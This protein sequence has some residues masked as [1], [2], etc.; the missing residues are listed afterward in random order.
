MRATLNGETPE[1]SLPFDDQLVS[2]NPLIGQKITLS[3]LGQINCT[4]CGRKTKKSFSQGYCYPCFTRLPQCDRCIVSPELCHYE[5][6]TCR[7]SA[8]GEQHCL[9]SH[10]VYLANTSGLKVGI[11]RATQVPT[12]WIDQ[13]AVAALPILRVS[14]RLQSGLVERI[15]AE[16]VADK[17]NWRTLLKGSELA[18]DLSVE[19]DRLFELVAEPLLELENQHGLQN[20]QRLTTGEVLRISYPV[21]QYPS[22]VVALNLEKTPEITG[23]LLGIKGQYLIL[24]CGVLNIRKYTAYQVALSM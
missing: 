6:G 16:Q 19:R 9:Q 13:G 5:A 17:T 14:T 1:Y 11:T 8:W 2:V 3:W 22:K 7:D 20:I 21:V 12:R 4:H 10:V 15:F 23:T 18:L 24:D